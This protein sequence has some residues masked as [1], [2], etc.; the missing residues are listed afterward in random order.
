MDKLKLVLQD[1]NNET[2]LVIIPNSVNEL[3]EHH[4]DMIGKKYMG[5]VSELITKIKELEDKYEMILLTHQ[6]EIQ[7]KDAEMKDKVI[8]LKDK[9]AEIIREKHEKEILQLKLELQL[10]RQ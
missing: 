1:Y 3:V 7:K 4:Y 8:E 5:H 2:E 10:S 6:I 9:D